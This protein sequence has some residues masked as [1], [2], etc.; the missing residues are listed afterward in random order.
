MV[1]IVLDQNH[2]ELVAAALQEFAPNHFVGRGVW[3]GKK[4]V[5]RIRGSGLLD[6][7]G[8]QRHPIFDVARLPRLQESIG[9]GERGQVARIYASRRSLCP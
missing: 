5:E 1:L 4:S 6:M 3:M 8:K 9:G 2:W 7:T